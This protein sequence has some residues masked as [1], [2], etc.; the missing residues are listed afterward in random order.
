VAS[1]GN[2]AS[3]RA[4]IAGSLHGKLAPEVARGCPRARSAPPPPRSAGRSRRPRARAAGPSRV[5][6]PAPSRDTGTGRTR[7]ERR[8]QVG[9]DQPGP[10]RPPITPPCDGTRNAPADRKIAGHRRVGQSGSTGGL[11]A[12]M[13]G[14]TQVGAA[15]GRDPASRWR[16]RGVLAAAP[17]QTPS[18]EHAPSE[19]NEK[20]QQAVEPRCA[21]GGMPMRPTGGRGPR[22]V[23]AVANRRSRT[24]R[25]RLIRRDPGG[26]AEQPGGGVAGAGMRRR[27]TVR[28]GLPRP[29]EDRRRLWLVCRAASSRLANLAGSGAPTRDRRA[30]APT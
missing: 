24:G 26:R 17:R 19:R 7:G 29:A 25:S 5:A 20:Q 13:N 9:V 30:P 3:S 4:V 16:T 21:C 28:R 10:A 27:I 11:S 22:L 23:R 12:R 15:T 2:P 8:R 1:A 14:S 6:S 18:G